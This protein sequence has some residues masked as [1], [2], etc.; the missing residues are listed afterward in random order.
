MELTV[1]CQNYWQKEGYFTR[2]LTRVF[3]IEW[4][5]LSTSNKNSYVKHP[6]IIATWRNTTT[7][8]LLTNI[9]LNRYLKFAELLHEEMM[10][11]GGVAAKPLYHNNCRKVLGLLFL[12]SKHVSGNPFPQRSHSNLSSPLINCVLRTQ[13]CTEPSHTFEK[14]KIFKKVEASF[15][16]MPEHIE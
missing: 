4:S 3:F 13:S 14:Q 10:F 8:A 5:T 12:W 11:Q 16:C 6:F 1:G 9:E 7:T 15:T 2:L